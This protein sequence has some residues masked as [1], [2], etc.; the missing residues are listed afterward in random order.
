M[1]Y[2]LQAV[3]IEKLSLRGA[4]TSYRKIKIFCAASLFHTNVSF[5]NLE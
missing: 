1:D 4:S 5:T 3:L 2:Y